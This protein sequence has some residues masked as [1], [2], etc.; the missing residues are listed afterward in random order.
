MSFLLDLQVCGGRGNVTGTCPD[1]TCG[2][3]GCSDGNGTL[4]CGGTQCNGTVGESLR[5][6]QSAEDVTKN[7]TGLSEDL[8]N[9]ASQ[10]RL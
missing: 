9:I 5:A 10:V 1:E 7:L 2:G 4:L 6:L 3:A 8:K